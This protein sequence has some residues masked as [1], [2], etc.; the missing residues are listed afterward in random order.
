MNVSTTGRSVYA[1]NYVFSSGSLICTGSEKA[2]V[3]KAAAA[4]KV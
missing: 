3:V 2:G 4:G 1:K